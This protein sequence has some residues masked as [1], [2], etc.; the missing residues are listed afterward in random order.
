MIGLTLDRS[1]PALV[2]ASVRHRWLT[3]VADPV[4]LTFVPPLGRIAGRPRHFELIPR[5]GEGHLRDRVVSRQAVRE[6]ARCMLIASSGRI[7]LREGL[8]NAS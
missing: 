8:C 7:R 4:P 3:V 2:H 6:W 1:R 5:A